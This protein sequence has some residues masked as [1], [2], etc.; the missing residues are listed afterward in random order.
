MYYP[1]CQNEGCNKK[2]TN[3]ENDEWYCPTCDE[4]FEVPNYRYILN[5]KIED[6]TDELWVTLFDEMATEIFQKT[7][8]DLNDIV[9]S[10]V[11]Y[12]L[13][14]FIDLSIRNLIQIY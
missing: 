11:I 9:V 1:S 2:V 6:R 5:A 12:Y 10:M 3:T 4:T 13:Y 14:I 7:A 8:N